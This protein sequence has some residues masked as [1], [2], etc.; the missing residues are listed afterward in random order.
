[1]TTYVVTGLPPS[2]VGAVHETAAVVSPAVAVTPV[3]ALG[4]PGVVIA[5]DA[6]LD[7]ELPTRFVATTVN[8]YEV[9]FAKPVHDAAVPFTTQL[10][11]LGDDVTVYPV[12]DAPPLFA[13]AV[14]ET[15]ADRTPA[16]AMTDVGASG[17]V[18]GVTAADAA[19]ASEL[20]ALF[21][22]TTVKVYAVPFVKPVQLAV[23]PVTA[24]VPPAGD[25]VTV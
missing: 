25:D 2:L 15:F 8:V 7:A 1:V 14:H 12:I 5:A 10:A 17:V 18:A 23:T 19:L 6:A 24:H 3:G 21:V 13:G 20:P 9:A 11:P 22:A 4:S 16:V